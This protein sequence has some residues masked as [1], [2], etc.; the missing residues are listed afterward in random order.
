MSVSAGIDIGPAG[1]V[2]PTAPGRVL[3]SAQRNEGPFLLEWLIYHLCI[4]F[5]R[6]VIYSNDCTD[7]SDEL[8]DVLARHLPLDHR[9]HEVT[10]ASTPFQSA[11]S[12]VRA[13]GLLLP[14]DWVAW[15]DADEFLN[16]HAGARR[17]D[18]L[19]SAIGGADAVCL[20]WRIFGSAGVSH[21]PG[22]QLDPVFVRCGGR[23]SKSARYGKT[24]FRFGPA[25][26][27]LSQHRPV[28]A[29]D[30]PPQ[31]W[32]NAAGRPLPQA[33]VTRPAARTGNLNAIPGWPRYRLAQINH[34]AVRTPDMFALRQARGR[35]S[36]RK[37][38]D[39]PGQSTRYTDRHYRRYDRNAFVDRSILPAA[40]AAAA[41]VDRLLRIPEI[42]DAQARCL[43]AAGLTG[44]GNC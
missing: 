3:F 41:E 24:L 16:I 21:W 39:G 34:Y 15:L 5:D 36:G 13:C 25:I 43:A 12:A 2:S 7:G 20:N 38:G 29:L 26:R 11:Q 22:R 27:S 4:G 19:I 42:A 9:T 28:L 6:A 31:R 18:D 37:S 35:G 8:L 30:A 44:A 10:E 40:A 1:P 32:V 23:L 14:G 33:Y 17:L